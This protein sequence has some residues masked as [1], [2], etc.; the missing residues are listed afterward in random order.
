MIFLYR[1]WN[2]STRPAESISF[3][4][5]VKNGWQAEQISTLRSVFVERVLNEFPQ[6]QATS[7]SWYSGWM[8]F[9]MFLDLFLAANRGIIGNTLPPRNQPAQ[10]CKKGVRNLFYI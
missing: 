5:P 1:F 6:A 10:S 2:R 3:C 4:L 9:L 7:T 8:P